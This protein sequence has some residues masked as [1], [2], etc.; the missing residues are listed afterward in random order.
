MKAHRISR[1]FKIGIPGQQLLKENF[2]FES[3]GVR[4]EAEMFANSESQVWIRRTRRH[5]GLGIVA[6][7]LLEEFILGIRI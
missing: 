5:E 1:K 2:G 3:G 7:H 6:K 4:A